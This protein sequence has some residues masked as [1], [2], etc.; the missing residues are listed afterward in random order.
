MTKEGIDKLFMQSPLGYAYY[1]IVF[2]NREHTQEYVLAEANDAF[3]DLW[4]LDKEKAL[5]QN[6]S[7]LLKDKTESLAWHTFQES[8][9]SAEKDRH[10]T[11]T[12]GK[13]SFKV[14]VYNPSPNS[15]ITIFDDTTE[16]HRE[17]ES[18]REENERLSREIEIFFNSTQDGLFFLEYKN[19]EFRYIRNN[20]VHQKLTGMTPPSHGRKDAHRSNG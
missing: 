10:F 20:M 2:G 4:G 3:F 1:E 5:H 11:V 18:Q 8:L 6:V 9:G 14:T 7:L 12:I 13:R 16:I 15:L 17:L 19:G